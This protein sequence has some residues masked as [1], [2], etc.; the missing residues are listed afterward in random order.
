VPAFIPPSEPVESDTPPTGK[1]WAHEVKFDGY[2]LQ[3]VK[4]GDR[5]HVLSKNGKDLTARFR[6]LARAAEA[7]PCEGCEVGS[8]RYRLSTLSGKCR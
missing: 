8:S 3:I 5:T 6:G 4:A 1:G 2:R 7:L